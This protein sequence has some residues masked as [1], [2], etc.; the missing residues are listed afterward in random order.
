MKNTKLFYLLSSLSANELKGFNKFINS[1]FH[2][3]N[4]KIILLFTL[5]KK[6]LTGQNRKVPDIK[7]LYIKIYPGKEYNDFIIRNLLSQMV[8]LFEEF[9]YVSMLK[10]DFMGQEK[11]ILEN[12]R[13]NNHDVLYEKKINEAI[14]NLKKNKIKDEKYFL[15]MH[16][17]LL[18]KRTFEEKQIQPGKRQ[19]IYDSIND[20]ANAAILF[21]VTLMLKKY[22]SILNYKRAINFS[23]NIHLYHDVM[24]L[25]DSNKHLQ[26]GNLLL[27][28]LFDFL[29]IYEAN[30]NN[31][32]Y[33]KI[34]SLVFKNK[35]LLPID[36][37]N[38]FCIEL[39]NYAKQKRTVNDPEFKTE[40]YEILKL[41]VKE[42]ILLEDKYM[43]AHSYINIA[44]SA[45]FEKDF[46]WA[47]NF[48]ENYKDKVLPLQMENAYNFNLS[49][50]YYLK[51]YELSDSKIKNDFYNKSLEIISRVKSEDF[52]Y[53]I[54]I[55]KHQIKIYYELGEFI[56]MEN[57]ITGFRQYLNQN[58]KM[59][60]E[61]KEMNFIF[62]NYINKLKTLRLTPSKPA[63]KNLLMEITG[64]DKMELKSWFIERI[65]DLKKPS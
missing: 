21:F 29:V 62:I 2:N 11:Y 50:L 60:D 13:V 58:N 15:L 17:L 42:D 20:E 8:K 40:S 3:S 52:Y 61:M 24:K 38:N 16:E 35:N 7:E 54:R 12:F 30:G 45:F 43:T 32:L 39:Y 37:Y 22:F 19:Q 18:E 5:L 10:K 9:I 31:D 23:H 47:E 64:R 36:D 34:K 63:I 53:M 27:E 14:D 65:K 33:F 6:Y 51:G 41:L 25:L 44:A 49:V 4:K 26:K 48:I 59:S 28:I 46:K 56:N 1:P 57:T 55:K